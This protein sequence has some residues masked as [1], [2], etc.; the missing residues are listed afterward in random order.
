MLPKEITSL[1]KINEVKKGVF[2]NET[3]NYLIYYGSPTN[4][5]QVSP[6]VY[7]LSVLYDRKALKWL[8]FQIIRIQ[9]NSLVGA[10][11]QTQ[12]DS[13]LK[14]LYSTI[15]PLSPKNLSSLQVREVI[16]G[17]FSNDTVSYVVYYDRPASDQLVTACYLTI[18]YN[19]SVNQSLLF[20]FIEIHTNSVT[21]LV[22]SY[23]QI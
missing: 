11:S 15:V 3:V 22:L 20:Q 19:P 4:N 17:T 23:A 6:N 18:L 21:Y 1:L 2:P 16:K 14:S 13:L 5:S 7:Y 12:A 10:Y 9:D 8:S